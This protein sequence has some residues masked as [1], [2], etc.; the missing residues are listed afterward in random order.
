MVREFD[1]V[2]EH[3]EDEVVECARQSG[4]S[5]RIRSKLA[6][7]TANSV[8]GPSEETVAAR[9]ECRKKPISPTTVWVVRRR[10]RSDCPSLPEISI[11]TFPA[12]TRSHR[13]G[14]SPSR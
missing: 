13:I 9:V 11:A 4:R 1:A 14:G 5:R 3:A 7:V 2:R 8:A 6:R 12:A 10:S